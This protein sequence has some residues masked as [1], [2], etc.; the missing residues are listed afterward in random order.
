MNTIRNKFIYEWKCKLSN[1]TQNPIL[2]TYTLFKTDF[3]SEPYLE[4]VTNSKYRTALTK[5][6]T[7]SHTLEIERGRHTK[8][9]TPINLRLCHICDLVEDEF[10]FF[11]E[12]SLYDTDRKTLLTNVSYKYPLFAD[13]SAYEKFIFLMSFNDSQIHSWVAKFVYRSFTLRSKQ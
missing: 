8:P 13:I 4:T 6:R 2:R 12:C 7:S 9:I 5:F 3:H 11:M 1:L 10:H